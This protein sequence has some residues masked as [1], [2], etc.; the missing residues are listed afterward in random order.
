M[1]PFPGAG[2]VPGHYEIVRLIGRGGIG[3]VYE[4]RQ[5]DLGRAVALKILSPELAEDPDFRSRFAREARMLAALDSPHVIQVFDSGERH[6]T[7]HCNTAG[8]RS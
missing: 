4:A 8:Q 6:G 3:A 2:G 5:L 1:T 7:L